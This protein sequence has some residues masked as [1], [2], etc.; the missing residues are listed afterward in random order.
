M[1]FPGGRQ[2]WVP[3]DLHGGD[4]ADGEFGKRADGRDM[5]NRPPRWKSSWDRPATFRGRGRG[6]GGGFQRGRGGRR[7]PPRSRLFISTSLL[8][9]MSVCL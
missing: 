7:R 9:V 2:K 1:L 3:L 4:L 8:Y 6:G 5:F